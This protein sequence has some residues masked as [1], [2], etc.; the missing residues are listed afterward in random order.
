MM[1]VV[2]GSCRTPAGRTPGEVID[3]STITTKMK[4][5]LF[6][7][8]IMRGASISVDT[9]EGNVTLTGDKDMFQVLNMGSAAR[10]RA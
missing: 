8:N 3:D 5:K 1:V 9:F 10:C 7:D 4:A 2:L 6:N